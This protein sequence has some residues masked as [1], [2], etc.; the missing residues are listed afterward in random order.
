MLITQPIEGVIVDAVCEAEWEFDVDFS[1]M[2]IRPTGH[3]GSHR[4]RIVGNGDVE[5]EVTWS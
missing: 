2:C 3:K 1:V 5:A 4:A